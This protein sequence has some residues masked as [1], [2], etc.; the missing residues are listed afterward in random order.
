M[1]WKNSNIPKSTETQLVNGTLIP[2]A[3]YENSDLS[4]R[5]LNYQERRRK[6]NWL[7]RNSTFKNV[8][9]TLEPHSQ[10][11]LFYRNKY[12]KR[13]IASMNT[14]ILKYFKHMA[15]EIKTAGRVTVEGNGKSK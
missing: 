11:T 9:H 8:C 7:K 6:D 14:N 13:L 5:N 3:T 15:R 10:M 1:T 12:C 4:C 2:V